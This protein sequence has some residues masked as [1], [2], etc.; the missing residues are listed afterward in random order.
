VAAALAVCGWLLSQAATLAPSPDGITVYDAVNNVTWLADANLAAINR[1][2]L[3][4]C[5]VSGAQPCI[6]PSGSMSYQAAAAWV[7]AMNAANYL[8]H[9]DWQLPATPFTDKT[10]PKTGP[11]GT[12]FGFGCTGGALGS[13]CYNGLG[14]KAPNTAVP[15]PNITAG[16]FSNFQP[17]LYWSQSSGQG[18]NAT[19][20]FNSGFQGANTADNFLYTLTMIPGKSPANLSGQTVYDPVTN[21]TWL[22]NANLAATNTFGLPP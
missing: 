9:T 7:Q 12:S 14:L 3:P 22:A 1:F 11:N 18:G 2:S 5:N 19:L 8:G 13:L 4:V 15:V 20:S 6:N 10:C 17:Y 16:L 21:V